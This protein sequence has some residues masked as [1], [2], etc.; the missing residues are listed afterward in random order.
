MN[1]LFL[2]ILGLNTLHVHVYHWSLQAHLPNA[3][4]NLKT[5]SSIIKDLF[6]IIDESIIKRVCYDEVGTLTGDTAMA[7]NE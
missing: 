2:R 4:K 7:T 5:K 3:L 1:Y 6:G